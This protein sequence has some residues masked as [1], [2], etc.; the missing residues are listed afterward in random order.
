MDEITQNAICKEDFADYLKSKD[1]WISMGGYKEVGFMACEP[2]LGYLMLK[3]AFL[4][5]KLY[6]FK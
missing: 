4:C 2:L 5:K 3:S 1:I 6:G